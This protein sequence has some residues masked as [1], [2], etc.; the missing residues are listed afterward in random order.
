LL[1]PPTLALLASRGPFTAV[2]VVVVVAA[3]DAASLRPADSD[4]RPESN[5]KRRTALMS[6]AALAYRSPDPF[7][8]AN[9]LLKSLRA[10]HPTRFNRVG[11]RVLN[12]TVAIT[13]S[14]SSFYAKSLAFEG[15]R[16]VFRDASIVDALEV[17]D[18]RG[19]TLRP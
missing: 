4:G 9:V 1:L 13:G 19:F 10:T 6:Q 16:A 15:A 2:V 17:T 8:A 11:V 12:G 18:R 7:A 5:N 14:V 3:S